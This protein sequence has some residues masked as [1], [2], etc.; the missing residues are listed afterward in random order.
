V[1]RPGRGD[2]LDIEPVSASPGSPSTD[3]LLAA[4][5]DERG[6]DRPG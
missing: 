1:I 4:G 6:G 5:R 2:P 3:E